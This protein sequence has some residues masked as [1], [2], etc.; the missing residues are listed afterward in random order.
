[1]PS[2]RNLDAVARLVEASEAAYDSAVEAAGLR[3]EILSDALIA[4]LGLEAVPANERR[5]GW[6]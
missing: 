1:M 3:R 4:E 5:D 6:H 2:E